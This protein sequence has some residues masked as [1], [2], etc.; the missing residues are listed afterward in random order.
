MGISK[1]KPVYAKQAYRLCLLG[2]TNENLAIYFGVSESCIEA[3]CR[4]HKDFKKALKKGRWSADSK[5]AKTLYQKALD[6]NIT[7]C[8]F[9]LKCRQ[10]AIW[11]DDIIED[12]GPEILTIK[13]PFRK[14]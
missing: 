1:Y 13:N 2:L 6:G 3:W 7:A 11:R 4:N 5:V 12:K 10:R 8:I 14:E 9:W